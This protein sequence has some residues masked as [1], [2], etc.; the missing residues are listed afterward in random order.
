MAVAMAIFDQLSTYIYVYPDNYPNN[1]YCEKKLNCPHRES[2]FC[3]FTASIQY[4]VGK[5][6]TA[7]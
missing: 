4:A 5:V 2:N 7:T 6:H 3:Q 1:I